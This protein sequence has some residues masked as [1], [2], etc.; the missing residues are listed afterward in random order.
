MNFII[1][2][3]IQKTFNFAH[4]FT[5]N[6]I[7]AF[8]P[9][10]TLT[11]FAQRHIGVSSHELTSM[12]KTIGVPSLDQ[13]INETVPAGIRMDKPLKLPEALTEYEYLTMLDKIAKKK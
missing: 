7:N 1:F 13:L 8:M 11:H 3:K 12:L 6:Q 10:N 4:H 5:T 9:S 2:H